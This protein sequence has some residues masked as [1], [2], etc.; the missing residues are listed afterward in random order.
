MATNTGAT[1][2]TTGNAGVNWGAEAAKQLGTN[3]NEKTSPVVGPVTNNPELAA[4]LNHAEN[5][6]MPPSNKGGK[7]RKHT[8]RKTKRKHTTRKTRHRMNRK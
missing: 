6:I 8:L 2:G 4:A 7:R 5:M 3:K 1:S